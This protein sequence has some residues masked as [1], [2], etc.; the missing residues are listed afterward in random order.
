[1]KD[2][3]RSQAGCILNAGHAGCFGIIRCKFRTGCGNEK[4]VDG[5]IA[6]EVRG[7]LSIEM[8][9]EEGRES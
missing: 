1:L 8:E 6:V 7:R 5:I 9:M 4:N 2:R 3:F